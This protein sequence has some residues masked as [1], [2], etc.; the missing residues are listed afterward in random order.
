[1]K[2]FVESKGEVQKDDE[3]DAE[4]EEEEEGEEAEPVKDEL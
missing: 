1:M 4:E 2:K 3:E